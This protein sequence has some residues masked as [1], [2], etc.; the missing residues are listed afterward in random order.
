MSAQ[1][2][3][4]REEEVAPECDTSLITGDWE[5]K[6]AAAYPPGYPRLCSSPECFGECVPEEAWNS[7]GTAEFDHREEVETLVRSNTHGHSRR[8]HRPEG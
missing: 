1:T 2:E 8:F 5:T 7:D 3:A 4:P 6:P